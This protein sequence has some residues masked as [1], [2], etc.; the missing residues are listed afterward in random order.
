MHIPRYITTLTGITNEMVADA[1]KFEEVA[2]N[3][4]NLLKDN[5]FVAHNVSFDYSFVLN[6][7]KTAG[8]TL[9]CKNF[10]PFVLA[11]KYFPG[12]P[13][14]VWETCVVHCILKCITATEQV[15]IVQPQP[16]FSFTS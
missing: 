14:T 5:I 15:E 10:V 9:N 16:K 7:L 2:S 8:Y 1:P 3:I 4:Y 13:L 12:F 11:A 6:H